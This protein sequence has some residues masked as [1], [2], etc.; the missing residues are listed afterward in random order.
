MIINKHCVRQCKVTSRKYALKQGNRI[1]V[2]FI[3]YGMQGV[4]LECAEI[5]H[6]RLCDNVED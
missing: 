5:L 6:T 4:F 2:R 3:K 1:G